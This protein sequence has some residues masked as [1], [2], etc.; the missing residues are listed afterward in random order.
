MSGNLASNIELSTLKE[1]AI[2]ATDNYIVVSASTPVVQEDIVMSDGNEQASSVLSSN[3]PSQ[4]SPVFELNTFSAIADD[5]DESDSELIN[6]L[7]EAITTKKHDLSAWSKLY[8]RTLVKMHKNPLDVNYQMWQREA[9]QL[10]EVVRRLC[11][12]GSSP[13]SRPTDG[14]NHYRSDGDYGRQCQSQH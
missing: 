12:S 7:E 9:I 1:L 8:R 4:P 2:N 13:G 14:T 10:L 6:G 3:L 11:A 5:D